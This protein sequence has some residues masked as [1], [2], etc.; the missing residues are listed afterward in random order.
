MIEHT[1]R[2]GLGNK[3]VDFERRVGELA[4]AHLQLRPQ[5]PKH[6]DTIVW[7]VVRAV[8]H[9]TIRYVLDQPSIDHDEFL[10]ELTAVS[11]IT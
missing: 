4:I 9:L 8:E 3:I 11:A 10:D 6:A 5:P 2:V 1:P 7:I